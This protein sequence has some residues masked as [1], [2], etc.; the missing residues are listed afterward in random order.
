MYDAILKT[1]TGDPE[2]EFT[3]RSTPYPLTNEVKKRVRTGD[4][5]TVIF[6]S[7]ISYSIVITVIISYLVVERVSQ[8]KHVQVITGMR[9]SSYW[10]V[11][12]IFDS[13]KLYVVIATSLLMFHLFGQTYPTAT[14]ILLAFPFGIIPFTY[15]FSYMFS[16]E[17][18]AQTFTFFCH[19]FVILFASLLIFILRVVPTLEVLGD[20]THYAARFFPSYSVAS[21]LYVD[22][23]ISFISQI[24]NTTDGDGADISPDPWHWN[25]NT[26]DLLA[27]GFHFV[28]WFFVLFLIEAD[29]GK[30]LRRC[31]HCLCRRALP[32]KKDDMKL[33]ADVEAEKLLVANTPADQYKIK[34]EGLRKVYQINGGCCNPLKPLVAVEN[35]SF[36]LQAGEC[37][38]LLGVNGAGKSTTFKSLTAEVEPTEGSIH[39]GA[40]DTR[41][42]FDNIK[43]LVGYC[44]QTNAIFDYMSVEENIFYFARIKGIPKERL[45][46]L[47][48]RAI[49]QLDLENHRFKLAGTLSG[50]NKRKLCVAMAIVGSPPIILLDEPSAGM[51]PEARR[52]MWR[53]VGQIASDK[54]SAVILTTHSMEEAEAL[55]SKMG[56]MVKGGIF[57]CFGTP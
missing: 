5:G 18:A 2:F 41:K 17:S 22:A 45:A 51:D 1:A 31:Y 46:E 28:F 9:L 35:I 8:L 49:K 37:F 15:V 32:K 40:L 54:T 26:L 36:G 53:V 25:N 4:A 39:I 14:W 50:G 29:L 38:A 16:V 11:N 27:Q 13:F 10:I 52:F 43:K 47:C 48:N 20:Q 7:A 56:I 12:F 30:R 33:D 42:D 34:V 44:P 55:S 24:R 23:S 19:M 21:S 57:K 3:T 6:F